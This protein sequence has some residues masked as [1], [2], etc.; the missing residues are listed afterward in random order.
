MCRCPGVELMKKRLTYV[1]N[2]IIEAIPEIVTKAHKSKGFFA[3][4]FGIVE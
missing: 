4:I 2:E 1:P 3:K